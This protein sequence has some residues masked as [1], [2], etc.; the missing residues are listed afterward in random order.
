MNISIL[1]GDSADARKIETNLLKSLAD[2]QQQ[3]RNSEIVLTAKSSYGD[4]VAGLSG[5][6]S[7][8]WLLIKTLWTDEQYRE[9]GIASELL[10]SAEN[11][12]VSLGCH[13][14]W[15]DTSNSV[16]RIF[17]QHRGYKDFSRLANGTTRFP[18]DHCRWFMKKNL[19]DTGDS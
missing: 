13:G 19:T 7:Y 12:A 11:R 17:Y 4:L 8:G 16:A 5:S 15:L 14:A 1:E 10:E 9:Q 2:T 18:N 3:A 6:T